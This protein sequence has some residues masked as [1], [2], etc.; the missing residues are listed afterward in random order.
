MDASG[1]SLTRR[2]IRIA[3]REL[4]ET[5]LLLCLMLA[6]L[7]L[8]TGLLGAR[9]SDAGGL[10][11]FLGDLTRDAH[12]I[13]IWQRFRGAVGLSARLIGGSLALSIP[14]ATA[15]GW[16][17]ALYRPVRLSR[18]LITA[19]SALPMVAAGAFL[20]QYSNHILLPIL[21][22]AVTE[23]TLGTM[24]A[25]IY[26][27]LSRELRSAYLDTT[28]A[29]GAA[30][31]T[32]YWKPLLA[33]I[34]STIRPRI[35]YLL[36]ATIV[37]ERIFSMSSYGLSNLVINAVEQRG[38]AS[39]LFWVTAFGLLLVRGMSLA[40]RLLAGLLDP[41]EGAERTARAS[42]SLAGWFGHLRPRLWPQQLAGLP[43]TALSALGQTARRVHDRLG[44]HLGMGAFAWAQLA[45]GGAF[46]LATL[47][48]IV[49]CASGW[50]PHE[51]EL[52][53]SRMLAPP[54]W[55]T[56]HYLGHDQMGRDLLSS[57]LRAGRNMLVPVAQALALPILLGTLLGIWV[58]SSRGPLAFLA[59][60][61]VDMFESL[62]KLI[63]IL[64]AMWR[65]NVDADYL[66]RLLPL[67]GLTFTPQVF[68]AVRDRTRQIAS[69]GFLEAQQALGSSPARVLGLHVLWNN[70]RGAIIVQGSL[71][72]GY[73]LMMDL[74][75]SYLK[76]YQVDE[77]L[78]TWGSLAYHG[79]YERR[80][81]SVGPWNPWLL[82]APLGI[83]ALFTITFALW[84][85]ALRSVFGSDQR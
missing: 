40:E 33:S 58:G 55:S 75:L 84:G 70:C 36:G 56:G 74:T 24:A 5:L 31:I 2:L 65:L 10:L 4:L 81:W 60:A 79:I 49:L 45:V 38:D 12:G 3:L 18:F 59:G 85:D 69:E 54:D 20:Q 43:R 82:Q 63:I 30:P 52:D 73:I 72:L 9:K 26:T 21:V 71:V 62:P 53:P 34:V 1:G 6:S 66:A 11:S 35:P 48:V 57:L 25:Q 64:A 8:L 15:V 42:A 32:H 78:M 76:Y 77:D 80:I 83:V 7:Y 22:L 14:L 28:R 47:G 29:K 16:M 27:D 50:M 39:I 17:A 51:L 37:V 41:R 67:V 44:E 13:P 61:L 23:L 46:S 68:Y 19:L